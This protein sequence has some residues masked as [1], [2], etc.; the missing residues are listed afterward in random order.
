MSASMAAKAWRTALPLPWMGAGRT[1]APALRA[2]SAVA[3]V[4]LLSNTRMRAAGS[5]ARKSRTTVPM[6]A[7][8]L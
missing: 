8:S 6:A 5:A 2:T 3:S 4:E 7:A 1:S